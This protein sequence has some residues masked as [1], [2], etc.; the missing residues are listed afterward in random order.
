V[1]DGV[2]SRLERKADR[3]ADDL[4]HRIVTGELPVGA[5]LP[6][7][8]ALAAHYDV[9][10]SVIR[11]AVK[12]LEVH[13]LV[14]PVR[15]RGTEVLDPMMSLSPEVLRAMLSPR[16]GEVDREFL[17]DFLELR[18]ALDVQLTMLAAERRTDEDLAALDAALAKLGAALS[19]RARYDREALAF[20]RVVARATHNR[21]FAMLVWWHQSVALELAHIFGVVRPANEAHFQGCTLLV[22]LIRKQ[23]IEQVRTLVTAFHAWATPRMLA[24]AALS[25]GAPLS[26]VMEGSL[27]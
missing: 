14:H 26:D 1:S 2:G 21:I 10:R 8:D 12:L 25:S 7:E 24:A 4:L 23:E 13:R 3:V 15:R 6:K 18:A 22:E 17:A 20:P 9:N 11:E 5:L 27:R 19:D 16:S